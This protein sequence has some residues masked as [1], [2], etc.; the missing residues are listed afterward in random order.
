MVRA[1]A[2]GWILGFFWI[3]VFA[4]PAMGF[5]PRSGSTVVVSQVLKDDLYLAGGTVITTAAVDGDVV[6]AGGTLDLAGGATGGMLVAGGTVTVGGAIGRSLRAAGGSVT[7]DSQISGD[8]V[9]AGG[10][11]RVHPAARIGRDLVV[12]GGTVSVAGTVGRNA[13]IGGGNVVIGGAIH[14]DAEVQASRIVLLSTARIGGALRYFADQPIEVQSGARVA[15]ETTQVQRS[16]RPRGLNGSPLSA[17]FWLWRSAVEMIAL[18]VLGFVTFGVAPRGATAVTREVG[19]RFWRSLAIGFVLLVTVPVAAVLLMFSVIA[20]PLSMIAVLLYFATVYPGQL[21]VAAW[22][23]KAILTR[24]GR[25][26]EGTPSAYASLVVGTLV[27][28]IGLAV[29]FAGWAIRLA[30]VCA[31]FG[32]LWVIL[33]AGVTARPVVSAT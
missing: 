30:V 11:V 29:P 25:G 23:G 8:A 27:L 7:V 1:W 10:A 14:G 12:E 17:R 26:S 13:L 20:I 3:G 16:P 33:W 31:G 32:A 24:I 2:R 6:A 22:L 4:S 5:V 28:V 18:L 15:G 19:E 21:F 9:V